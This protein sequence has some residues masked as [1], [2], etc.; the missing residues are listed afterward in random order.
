MQL[1][2]ACEWLANICPFKGDFTL[3]CLKVWILP[4]GIFKHR[5]CALDEHRC[6][7]SGVLS[8]V[9]KDDFCALWPLVGTAAKRIDAL[10]NRG[11]VIGIGSGSNSVQ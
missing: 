1:D 3:A 7:G 11:A 4:Q 5:G 2:K 10:R 8:E 9:A 6:A